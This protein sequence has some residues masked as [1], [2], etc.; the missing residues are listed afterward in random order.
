MFGVGMG[1]REFRMP[2]LTVTYEPYGDDADDLPGMAKAD[3]EPDAD[4]E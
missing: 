3:P 4:A 1:H 2:P